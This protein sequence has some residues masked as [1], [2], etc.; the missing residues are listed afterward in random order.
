ME[1]LII[2]RDCQVIDEI[3]T[4]FGLALRD[5]K[6]ITT[7]SGRECLDKAED[8]SL[9]LDIWGLDLADMSGFDVLMKS[10]ASLTP[11]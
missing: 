8:N 6:P 9:D 5:C 3:T 11:L 1:A 10:A 7:E 2:E 4:A